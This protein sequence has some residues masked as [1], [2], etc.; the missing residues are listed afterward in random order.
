MNLLPKAQISISGANFS[1]VETE[2]DFFNRIGCG[3][4]RS[5]QQIGYL[6]LLELA[7]HTTPR[8][9]SACLAAMKVTVTL[10]VTFIR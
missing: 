6:A 8:V 3:F 4:N 1:A 2:A 7:R 5:T 10:S 9:E